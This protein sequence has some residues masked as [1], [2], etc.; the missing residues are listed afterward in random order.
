M[1]ED[2]SLHAASTPDPGSLLGV[3]AG[4][5][6][7]TAEYAA[8]ARELDALRS[9]HRLELAERLRV[10]RGFGGAADND[11]LLAVLEEAAIDEAR[12]A[13]LEEE[14]RSARVIDPELA[15]VG[16][17]GIGATVR[18]VDDSG[19]ECEYDLVGR[20]MPDYHRHAVTPGSPVG[21][22]LMAARAGDVVHV[23]LPS[24]RV[25]VLEVLEVRYP[26]AAEAA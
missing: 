5:T 23:E 26:G 22:A 16:A 12:I 11:D 8:L 15:E 2:A 3:P 9:R 7:T 21:E 6:L 1:A 17:A 20:R 13:Q 10:A 24:G 18:V 19:R 4:R 25:R 14:M